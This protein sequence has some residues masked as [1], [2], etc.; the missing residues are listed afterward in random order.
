MGKSG[1][2]VVNVSDRERWASQ[3]HNGRNEI[4]IGRGSKWGNRYRIGVDGDRAEVISKFGA[5]IL[6]QPKLL[7][8]LPELQGKTLVCHCKP[9]P[10]HGDSLKWLVENYNERR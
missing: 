8:A 5:W 7:K 6:E 9:K 3:V 4:Y 2:R 10:C 1:I